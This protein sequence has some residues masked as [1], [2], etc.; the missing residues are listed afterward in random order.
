MAGVFLGIPLMLVG[1]FVPRPKI[2][3][4]LVYIACLVL[5]LRDKTFDCGCFA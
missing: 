4:P 3:L 2:I 1:D 5:L